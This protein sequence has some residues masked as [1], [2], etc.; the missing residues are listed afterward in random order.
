M[1]K[2]R[3][4]FLYAISICF[5]L[6]LVF[7]IY[8]IIAVKIK[9][10]TPND[11]TSL[12]WE[13]QKLDS[14]FWVCGERN[15]FK[16]SNTSLWELY[17]EGDAFERGVANGKLTTSLI[18]KQEIAFV[19]Q[20]NK[21]IPS[22][23]YLQFLK[24]FVAWFNR[25]LDEDVTQ[26]H[27][28]EI[29]GL[30]LSSPDSF[31]YIGPKYQRILNYHAAHDIGHAL[32]NM[33]LVGC[34]SFA[35]WGDKSTDSML[36]IGRNFDFYV[37]DEFAED[38]VIVFTN[39][40]EGYKFMSV[41][42][43]GMIG[44]VSGMN[45]KGLTITLN[46]AKSDVPGSS[47]TP[48]ALVA[49]EILQYAQNIEEAYAIAKKRN[50]F[51]AESFLI[52]SAIDGKAA[53]IEKTPRQMALFEPDS[54]LLICTNHFQSDIFKNDSLNVTHIR[55]SASAYRYQRMEQ[56][57]ADSVKVDYTKAATILRDQGGINNANIG[58]GNEK[59]VNQLIAHHSIIFQPEK[60]LVWVSTD[61]Y[62][63]GPYVAYDLHYVFDSLA[64][65]RQNKTIYESSLT[66]HTDSFLYSK[67]YIDFVKFKEIKQLIEANLK[68]SKENTLPQKTIATLLASNPQYY[69]TYQLAGNYYKKQE[70][71]EKASIYYQIALSKEI[72]TYY[73]RDHIQEQLRECLE[74]TTDF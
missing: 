3:K 36:L 29:Y 65:L 38:K 46:A 4:L 1:Q 26:E 8:F 49:R 35:A 25:D 18:E 61:P 66:I 50:T 9:P 40:K 32:Q 68:E 20:I 21:M 63:L 12:N 64:G 43:G 15:W 51:V 16:K 17:V 53:V 71:F 34:T 7:I 73:E 33:S 67:Q 59:A 24:F 69:H 2:L 56:L 11:L 41:S 6:L 30:S 5:F 57:L 72:N 58:R 42:W 47:A 70:D 44:A 39:P 60:L 31:N 54:N 10:P 45:E 27:Q 55:E 62:Q 48:V 37:G 13:T 14:A 23:G 52:G 22:S 74:Q 19:G 28:L